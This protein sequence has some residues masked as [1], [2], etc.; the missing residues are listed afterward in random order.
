M[1]LRIISAIITLIIISCASPESNNT[2]PSHEE[3]TVKKDTLVYDTHEI[4]S[5]TL[6][7]WNAYKQYAWGYDVL[8]PLSK[9][10]FN[11]YEESLGISPFDAYSTLAVMGLDKEAKEIEN[12]TL[13]MTIRKTRRY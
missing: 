2:P 13:F 5:E 1:K 7:S 4:K 3:S 10:G 9:K 8:L 11:W 12:Y 6:R